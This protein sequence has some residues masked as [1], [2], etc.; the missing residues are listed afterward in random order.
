[1][2][3]RTE[4]ILTPAEVTSILAEHFGFPREEC[5]LLGGPSVI[6]S[7]YILQRNEPFADVPPSERDNHDGWGLKKTLE[8]VTEIMDGGKRDPDF[9][10]CVLA[11]IRGRILTTMKAEG[12]ETP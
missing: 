9:L 1:M 4:K 3:N 7:E 8:Y 6:P 11:T 5:S 12:K 10:S 2:K